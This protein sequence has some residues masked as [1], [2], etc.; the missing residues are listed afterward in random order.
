MTTIRPAQTADLHGITEIF[1]EAILKTTSSFFLEPRTVDDMRQWLESHD[2][3]HP[4]LVAEVDSRVVGWTSLTKWSEREAYDG[5]AE[6]SFYV[7]ESH[8][9]QGIGRQL[10]QRIIE[11]ARGLNYHTLIARMAEGS[12]AS[13]HL[14]EQFGFE[15]VG[16]LK[17]VGL[18]FGR[19]LDVHIYQLM[20][21]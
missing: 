19:L 12:D 3:R 13:R 8:R 4:V 15:F 6:T 1:N 17:E 7:K 18:K 16:T 11:E 5:T 10:K 9:G 21:K 2:Q 20:L 14:N